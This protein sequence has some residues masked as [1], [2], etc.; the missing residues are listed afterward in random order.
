MLNTVPDFPESYKRRMVKH[1]R[2]LRPHPYPTGKITLMEEQ[3]RNKQP[4]TFE[5]PRPKLEAMKDQLVTAVNEKCSRLTEIMRLSLDATENK[6]LV[7]LM[8]ALDKDNTNTLRDELLSCLN[9][10]V[11][12]HAAKDTNQVVKL[13]IASLERFVVQKYK[14]ASTEAK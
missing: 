6:H 9:E 2:P 1:T 13:V 5:G 3:L 10:E 11:A 12:L 14:F 4:W 8:L 7:L